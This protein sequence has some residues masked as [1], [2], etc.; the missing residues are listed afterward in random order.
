[1]MLTGLS[2]SL[3]ISVLIE[4]GRTEIISNDYSKEFTLKYIVFLATLFSGF[5]TNYLEL[6]ESLSSSHCPDYD[7]SCLWYV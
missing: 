5:F 3:R 6:L 1:M 4:S 7:R 2:A